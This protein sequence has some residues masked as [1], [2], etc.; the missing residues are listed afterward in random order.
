MKRAKRIYILLGVLV[1]LCVATF[2]VSRY[3]EEQEKINTR[4]R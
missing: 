4:T 3:N 1:V 2:A